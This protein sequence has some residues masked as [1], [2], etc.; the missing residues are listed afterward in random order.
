MALGYA[1]WLKTNHKPTIRH[2]SCTQAAM[3][4]EKTPKTPV[5]EPGGRM[6]DT[7]CPDVFVFPCASLGKG[8]QGS[9]P[10]ANLP[11]AAGDGKQEE[12]GI[13]ERFFPPRFSRGLGAV[14]KIVSICRKSSCFPAPA[15]ARHV[16]RRK[17]TGRTWTRSPKTGKQEACVPADSGRSFARYLRRSSCAHG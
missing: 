9:F 10:L 12:P 2:L 3:T 6:A 1:L 5:S 13:A 4:P 11:A 15:V 14:E 7:C 16:A 8:R 17:R